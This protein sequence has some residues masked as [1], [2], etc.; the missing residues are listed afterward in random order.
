MHCMRSNRGGFLRDSGGRTD[1]N[2][3]GGKDLKTLTID[4]GG[5]GIKAFVLDEKGNPITERARLKTPRPALPQPIL[6]VISKLAEK[7]GEFDRV[8]IGFPGVVLHGV[9]HTAPNLDPSWTGFNL[10]EEVSSK[11]GRPVRVA[12]DADIQGYGVI[13][14]SGVEL[15]ITLGTGMGSAL[16]TDGVLVPNLELAH[17]P[18]D[19]ERTYEQYLGRRALDEVGKKEWSRRVLKVVDRLRALFN[20][21]HLYFG[22]GNAKKIRLE[23]P[24]SV[25]RVHNLAGLLGGIALWKSVE[26]KEESS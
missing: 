21:D 17:H 25:S 6:K 22:G 26:S 3:K 7:Q 11:L 16:F 2:A 5:S 19:G 9:T 10:A 12:N 24:P 1:M 18:Y 14:G 13:E 4:I 20:Y 23:L 8:S 15:V